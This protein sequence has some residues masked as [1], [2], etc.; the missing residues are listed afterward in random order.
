MSETLTIKNVGPI[1]FLEIEVPED[2]GVTVLR[3]CNGAGKSQALSAASRVLGGRDKLQARDG[4]V[5]GTI[6]GYGVKINVGSRITSSGQLEAE[7]IEGRLDLAAIVDPGIS[8]PVAADAKRIKA[9]VS[10]LGVVA[11]EALF[12][13]IAG[14]DLS[15]LGIVK[16]D[17]LV[18][19]AGRVKRALES[20]ARDEQVRADALKAEADALAGGAPY[21]S[22]V[23]RDALVLSGKLEA[24]IKHLAELERQAMLAGEDQTRREI[25]RDKLVDIPAP[26]VLQAKQE[27][28]VMVDAVY[29]AHK[30]LAEAQAAYDAA[31]HQHERSKDRL[32]AEEQRA[33]ERARFEE[34]IEAA[35]IESPSEIE[36]TS[37]RDAIALAR[38]ALEQGAEARKADEDRA[39]AAEIRKQAQSRH[40]VSEAYRDASRAAEGVLSDVVSKLGIGLEVRGGRLCTETRRGMTPFGELSDGERWRRAIDLGVQ[41]VG[42]RG[43]LSIAQTAWEGLDRDSRRSIHEHAKQRGVTILT[44]QAD[45]G[46]LR[47]ESFDSMMEG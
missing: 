40:K 47:A 28:A 35:P 22:E 33:A 31:C 15:E 20:K 3:G 7:S 36:V 44:A 14:G 25:A 16:T 30:R 17:D 18:E 29:E 10:I 27:E 19:L 4:A 46:D 23:E 21:D 5:K 11:D 2:G 43:V 41:R 42:E 38:Q 37:A 39:R 32:E 45:F 34:L 8:D 24:A 1:G 13:E 12:E 6:D 9:L 26:F